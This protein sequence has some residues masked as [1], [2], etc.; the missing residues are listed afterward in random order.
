M[1]LSMAF[2][3]FNLISLHAIIDRLRFLVVYTPYELL[4]S[5]SF[6]GVI[7]LHVYGF[8]T[9]YVL[10]YSKTYLK[11]PLKKKTKNWLSK[12]IIA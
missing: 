8:I 6:S 3:I 9:L 11:R 2:I 7:D 10:K 5:S 4:N 1:S 12:P